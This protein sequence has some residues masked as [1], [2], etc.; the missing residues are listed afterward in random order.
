MYSLRI[1]LFYLEHVFVVLFWQ[2]S[3]LL[4][5]RSLRRCRCYSYHSTTHMHLIHI[6]VFIELEITKNLW[7]CL[8][9]LVAAV[10]M[11]GMVD[12][13]EGRSG[14]SYDGR[15]GCEVAGPYG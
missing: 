1:A 14:G 6:G 12:G 11:N 4:Q 2:V 10:K 9:L 3:V 8:K 13:G 7:W 15:G 5:V